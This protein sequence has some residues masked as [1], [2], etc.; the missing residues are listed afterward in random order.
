MMLKNSEWRD[1]I[2]VT[3]SVAVLGLGLGCTMPLTALALNQR[4]QSAAVIGWMIALS[5]LGGI[6]GTLTAPA[7]TAWQGRRNVMLGCVCLAAA[8]VI[9]LQFVDSLSAWAL[10][11]FV[12]GLAMAPLFVLGEAWINVI[13]GDAVRGRIVA[14]YTT[15]FTLCQ[16]LGPLMTQLLTEAPRWMFLIA[17]GVFLLGVP[18]IAMARERGETPR[19]T[20]DFIA[21]KDSG[22]SW[23]YIAR[24]AP[25]MIAGAALFAAFDSTMLSFLPLTALDYGF[26][27]ALALTAVSITF[28]GDAAL[29]I[30]AGALADRYGR[31]HVQLLC[32]GMLCGLLP[33]MPI[34]LRLPVVWALYLF[35]LGGIAGAIYTLSLVSSGEQFAGA[36]LVRA[37]GLIALTWNLAATGA[38]LATGLGTRWVGNLAMVAMLWLIAIVFFFTLLLSEPDSRR[39]FVWWPK[40]HHPRALPQSQP[41]ADD[42]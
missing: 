22:A 32:A 2:A 17:G 24:R 5:A 29:Q 31:S 4:G 36:A 35:V 8:S 23:L 18:G 6:V 37:S 38:P 26:T 27:Q 7:M 11:R 20:G 19:T 9:P 16:V 28:A 40:S 30:V 42:D 12:F 3:S 1:F 10:L 14:I 21:S 25:A 33:F 39:G 34:A 15:S 41:R 13:P